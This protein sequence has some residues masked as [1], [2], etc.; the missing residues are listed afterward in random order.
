MEGIIK[1]RVGLITLVD[2]YNYGNRLQ[3][4]ASQFVLEQNNCEVTCFYT[5][6]TVHLY[7][8]YVLTFLFRTVF[9]VFSVIKN[10]FKK[11]L[12]FKAFDKEYFHMS[13]DLVKRRLHTDDYDFFVV[14]SDQVWNPNWYRGVKAEA[15]LL[16]FA[17]REQKVCMAPSFGI[18][19][20]P[21]EWKPHFKKYL[22]DFKY[23]SVR[24]K[25]GAKII[26]ELTGREAEVVIDPTL[27]LDASEWR[28]IEK[29]S[30][31]RKEGKK[32]ILKYFLGVQFPNNVE[33]INKIAH[34]YDYQILEL[35][36]TDQPDV[37]VSGPSEFIDLVDHAE[38]IC[39][40]SYH[41]CIFSILFDKPFLVFDRYSNKVKMN[42]RINT[43]LSTLDLERRLPGQ[44]KDED[45]FEHD[46]MHTYELLETER[47]KAKKF[48]KKSLNID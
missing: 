46:Y 4:Y 7:C 27:M 15:F 26:R 17:E 23:L 32:Y 3:C 44:V 16:A 18:S 14:G 40:D 47:D 41:A 21:E 35:M 12:K 9:R 39:T 36:Q 6:K 20:L 19:E 13:C 29:K 2:H 10:K 28:R 37:F 8:I 31:A 1:M 45:I 42:S 38:L 22:N 30:K 25:E 43:L 5:N 33:Y 24:E 48:L 11:L 34:Q